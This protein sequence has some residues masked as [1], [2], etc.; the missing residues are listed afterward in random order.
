MFG[1]VQIGVAIVASR[2]SQD[3]VNEALAIA[4]LTTGVLLGV[5]LLALFAKSANQTSAL[6]G[7]LTGVT[8]V[9]MVH[10]TKAT[11]WIWY[12]LIGAVSTFAAGWLA[13]LLVGT[14]EIE[15]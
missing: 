15:Q 10:L 12:A 4:G 11:G 1:L 6:V 3:V 14:K 7:M 8:I 9:L 5:F 13:S 2:I